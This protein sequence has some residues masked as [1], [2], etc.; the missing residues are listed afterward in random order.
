MLKSQVCSSSSLGSVWMRQSIRSSNIVCIDIALITENLI[1]LTWVQ[2]QR[3]AKCCYVWVNRLIKHVISAIL[4]FINPGN[5]LSSRLTACFLLFC[6][7]LIYPYYINITNPKVTL[8]VT[9]SRLNRCTGFNK[10]CIE[11]LGFLSKD[12]GYSLSQ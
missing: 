8:F 12:V 2:S 3:T 7:G 1:Q 10:I 11:I 6:H 5:R 4:L 9:F